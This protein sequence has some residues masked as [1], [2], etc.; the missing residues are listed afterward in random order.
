MKSA[1]SQNLDDILEKFEDYNENQNFEYIEGDSEDEN[2]MFFYK[3][4]HSQ[5]S[6]R[7]L[8]KNESQEKLNLTPFSKQQQ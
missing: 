5:L 7:N 4:D 3:D 2:D 8:S 1:M 6:K